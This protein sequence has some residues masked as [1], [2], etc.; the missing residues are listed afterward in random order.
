M[1][2]ELMMRQLEES[3]I[4]RRQLAEEVQLL[5][6]DMMEVERQANAKERERLQSLTVV[7]NKVQRKQTRFMMLLTELAILKNDLASLEE[8]AK[9]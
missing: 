5:R 2:V 8:F 7:S 4:G 1:Q 3:E 9:S 6:M